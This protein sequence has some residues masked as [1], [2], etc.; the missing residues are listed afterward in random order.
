MHDEIFTVIVILHTVSQ[1]SHTFV[2]LLYIHL[3]SMKVGTCWQIYTTV[4]PSLSVA[5]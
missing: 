4:N 3:Q 5:V 1:P 2:G